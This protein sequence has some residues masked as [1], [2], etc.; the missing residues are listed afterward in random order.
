MTQAQREARDEAIMADY[1]YRILT[2]A[3]LALLALGTVVYHLLEDWSWVDSLYFSSVA[4]STVGFGDL[5]PTRDI[6]KLFT[7]L[8]IFT[9]IAIITS[10]LNVRLRRHAA[11][12]ADR[13]RKRELSVS[14]EE[15]DAVVG[16]GSSHGSM[17][18]AGGDDG[19]TPNHGDPPES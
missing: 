7:I 16:D 19:G 14:P 10:F 12:V 15:S 18:S 2:A 4:V 13:V 3:A 9:G 8:Y 6:S 1:G 11:T 17:S 5:V